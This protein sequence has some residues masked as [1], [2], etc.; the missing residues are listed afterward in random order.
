MALNWLDE[1]PQTAQH[2]SSYGPQNTTYHNNS[3]FHL[4]AEP[5]KSTQKERSARADPSVAPP[6]KGPMPITFLTRN[7]FAALESKD[8]EEEGDHLD[9]YPILNDIPLPT[10]RKRMKKFPKGTSANAQRRQR[11]QGK[12]FD[13]ILKQLE[14]EDVKDQLNVLE[15]EP[16]DTPAFSASHS[17][18]HAGWSRIPCVLDSGAVQ[19][20]AP[21]EMAPGVPVLPSAGSK[22]GQHYLAAN[23]QR[24]ANIG[25][26]HIRVVT[27]EGGQADVTFQVTG[28]TRP[29][30]SVGELCDRGNRVVFGR[31]GG[32]IQNT[33]TGAITHFA[34]SGGIYAI[35]FFI[36]KST[37]NYQ[38]FPGQG[39]AM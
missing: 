34:R 31:G 10:M 14:D 35:D 4:Q 17:P 11:Q 2:A 7:A 39:T 36:P 12:E 15:N 38:G 18:Q 9:E 8:V 26:Q 6:T 24:M 37:P 25:E 28:V 32:V 21:P 20:V 19:S 1:L 33:S 13:A 30:L 29:L 5:E 27:E 23:G 22:R 16:D 3:I